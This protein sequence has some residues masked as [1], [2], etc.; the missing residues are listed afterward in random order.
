MPSLFGMTIM[1]LIVLRAGMASVI[2]MS[3][4]HPVIALETYVQV[5]VEGSIVNRI[6]LQQAS[7]PANK[8]GGKFLDFQNSIPKIRRLWT[9]PT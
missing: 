7:K 8:G 1:R 5:I 9:L 6:V 3:V 2:H 4:V